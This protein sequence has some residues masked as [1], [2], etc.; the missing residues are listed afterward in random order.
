MSVY[1]DIPTQSIFRVFWIPG[2]ALEHN[3]SPLTPQVNVQVSQSAFVP[4]PFGLGDPAGFLSSGWLK[5]VAAIAFVVSSTIYRAPMSL[6]E[7]CP[8]ISIL[9]LP[10]DM[11]KEEKAYK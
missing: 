2:S 7:V 11:V 1:Q 5:R 6:S 8:G 4:L 9:F 10:V 3:T